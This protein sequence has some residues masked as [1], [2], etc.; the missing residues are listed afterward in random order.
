VTSILAFNRR[1]GVRG[2]GEGAAEG[3]VDYVDR[4]AGWA[5]GLVQRFARR[6]GRAHLLR[7]EDLVRDPQAALGA[8]LEYL[9][10][11]A[12]SEVVAGMLDATR[13]EMPELAGHTTSGNPEASVGRWVAELDD[14][15]KRACERSFGTAL[16]AFGYQRSPGR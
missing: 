12:G 4:L 13:A 16:E 1:R 14:D 10:V 5:D 7:Y 11:D 2:F 15:L 6:P 3:P 8:L 9:E